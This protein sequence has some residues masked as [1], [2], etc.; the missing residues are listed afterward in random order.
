MD[1]RVHVSLRRKDDFGIT[2]NFSGIIPTSLA[3]KVYNELL[4]NNIRPEIE[5]IL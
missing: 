2:K 1:E 3:S 4:F 5:K